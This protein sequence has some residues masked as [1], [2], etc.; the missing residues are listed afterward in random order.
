MKEERLLPVGTRVFDV[1]F[2]F[3]KVKENDTLAFYPLDVEFDENAERYT[4]D[5]ELFLNDKVPVLSLTEYPLENGGFTPISEYFN[6][7]KVED[8]GYFWDDSVF[9]GIF[10]ARLIGIDQGEE[11]PYRA[12]GG[13]CWRNFSHDIP[14]HIKKQMQ[15]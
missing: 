9:H 10:F 3:G 1:Q 2:G 5:G 15:Q 6:N 14:D 12:G 4:R 13:E 8:W 11:S 7:P